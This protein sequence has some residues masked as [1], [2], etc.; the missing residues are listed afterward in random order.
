MINYC[1]RLCNCCY[2]CIFFNHRQYVW[3]VIHLEEC[4][5][6]VIYA[7][8]LVWEGKENCHE[9]LVWE[10]YENYPEALVW[11]GYD[12]CHEVLVWEGYENCH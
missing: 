3:P 10:W 6:N 2:R 8:H 4:Y 11:E 9:A 1:L 12:N 7:H 5:F